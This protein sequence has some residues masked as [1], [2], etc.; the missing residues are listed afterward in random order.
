TIRRYAPNSSSPASFPNDYTQRSSLAYDL[1]A[2]AGAAQ[3]RCPTFNNRTDWAQ[4]WNPGVTTT[5]A[6]DSGGAWGQVTTP[7]GTTY[8]EFFGTTGWQRGLTLQTETWSG[9]VRKKWS[10][11]QWVNNDMN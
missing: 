8:K 6:A 5:F 4:D 2:D 10:T 9:G 11:A 3:T 1:P 7:D